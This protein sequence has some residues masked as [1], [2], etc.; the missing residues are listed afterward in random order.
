[1]LTTSQQCKLLMC[2]KLSSRKIV[3]FKNNIFQ[4]DIFIKRD[5]PREF[6]NTNI[7][8]VAPPCARASYP[9]IRPFLSGGLGVP[10]R[11]CYSFDNTWLLMNTALRRVEIVLWISRLSLNSRLVHVP[12]AT[13]S[14]L[15]RLT[16]EAA[17]R[18]GRRA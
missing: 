14:D 3:V 6:A 12:P 11:Y 10:F 7:A 2:P 5:L 8:A 16:L 17:E 4:K 1:M 9:Q 13:D 15:A 18:R